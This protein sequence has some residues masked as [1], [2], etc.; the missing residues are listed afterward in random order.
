[1]Y[2]RGTHTIYVYNLYNKLCVFNLVPRV[3]ERTLGTRLLIVIL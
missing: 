3:L 1:M 2:P